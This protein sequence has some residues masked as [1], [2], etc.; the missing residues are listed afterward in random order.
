MATDE[1]KQNLHSPRCTTTHTTQNTKG[2][3]FRYRKS[4]CTACHQ[5]DLVLI[6]TVILSLRKNNVTMMF[7]AEEVGPEQMPASLEFATRPRHPTIAS[8]NSEIMQLC[9]RRGT[10]T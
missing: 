2:H 1:Q 4:A 5:R 8:H 3:H 10:V 6:D 7:F 9:L